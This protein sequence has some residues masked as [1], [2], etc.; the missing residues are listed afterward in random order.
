M[1]GK[2]KEKSK[3]NGNLKVFISLVVIILLIVLIIWLVNVDFSKDK[4]LDV[5]IPI[6]EASMEIG[7]VGVLKEGETVVDVNPEAV[8]NPIRPL[9]VKT[10]NDIFNTAGTIVKIQANSITIRGNGSNF[11][12][13]VKRDLNIV[14][15]EKT[16]INGVKGGL[17]YFK[18]NLSVGDRIMVEAPYNI[19]GKD[20]F[21]VSYINIIKK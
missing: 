17:D 16:N 13:Q 21:L 7:G 9:D 14:I 6:P 3:T 8:E 19:H 10:P 1:F 20:T 11:D 4:N 15:D 12:D 5:F 18:E 2:I